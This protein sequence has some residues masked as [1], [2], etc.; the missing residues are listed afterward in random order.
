MLKTLKRTL[1]LNPGTIKNIHIP[2]GNGVRIDTA[3]YSG[4]TIPPF[5]DSHDNEGY[6]I[7][8]RQENSD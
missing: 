6:D 5:Y 8:K 3:V 2:G 1:H 7:C 4:Y